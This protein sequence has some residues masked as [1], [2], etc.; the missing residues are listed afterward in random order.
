MSG[1][2]IEDH[3]LKA[4]EQNQ[5]RVFYQPQFNFR[6]GK[7]TGIEALLRWEHPELG[8]LSPSKFIPVAEETGLI[9]PIGEWVLQNACAR[10]KALQEVGFEPVPIAINLSAR[11]LCEK[12]LTETIARVLHETGLR[13]EYLSLEI[14]ETYEMH[15]F[16]RTT[17]TLKTLKEMGIQIAL[18]DFGTGYSSLNS[19][20]RF[21]IDLL[22]IDRGFL[23]NVC[24]D[25]QDSAIIT[26]ILALARSLRMSVIAEG[27][28]TR[29]QVEFL[30]S[31]NCDEMQGFYFSRPL[32]HELLYDFLRSREMVFRKKVH[33]V[34]SPVPA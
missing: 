22:K 15:H 26:A 3:L 6:T 9:V 5:F 33:V 12:S 23:K 32:P 18:D 14:T 25:R 34:D 10:S 13:V 7:V 21:P 28:E 20:K 1:M 31:V 30:E 24:G 19:L 16:E 4:M 27:V 29:E 17:S 11:Q 8:L 2:S